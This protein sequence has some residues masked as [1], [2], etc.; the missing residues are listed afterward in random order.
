M[1]AV[2]LCCLFLSALADPSG[3]YCGTFSSDATL[4]ATVIDTQHAAMSGTLYGTPLT[5]CPDEAAYL[6]KT[7]EHIVFPNIMAPTDCFGSQLS[8]YSISPS[9]V[10]VIYDAKANILNASITG[11]GFAVLAPCA[12]DAASPS[13]KYCG[14]YAGAVVVNVTVDSTSTFTLS[15]NIE[16]V[17]AQCQIEG[18]T[19]KSDGTVVF[20]NINSP[21]DCLGAILNSYG[22]NPTSVQVAWTASTDGLSISVP[23]LGAQF[24]LTHALCT[25]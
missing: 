10:E 25:A 16:G 7:N 24:T 18:Y 12:T 11:I 13:G 19:L 3:S 22:I 6:D 1:L 8:S 2:V 17:L 4:K 21:S 14:N 5:P 15:G 9:A 23:D 20:P